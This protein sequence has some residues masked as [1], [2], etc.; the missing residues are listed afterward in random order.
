MDDLYDEYVSLS[1]LSQANLTNHYTGLEIILERPK[2]RKKS[3][4]MKRIAQMPIWR[5]RMRT[6]KRLETA[7]S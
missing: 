7:S 5:M 4:S 3:P 1:L 6:K 2:N